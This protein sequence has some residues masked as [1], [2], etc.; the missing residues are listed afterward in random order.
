MS[1][2]PGHVQLVAACV[3]CVSLQLVFHGTQAA[4]G[5]ITLIDALRNLL[6]AALEDPLNQKMVLVSETGIPLFAPQL[7]YSQLIL[8]QES[9]LNSCSIKVRPVGP[10]ASK[11]D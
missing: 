10:P 8:E 6:A 2:T 1:I 5:S 3:A 7:I 9:R 4:W 11:H